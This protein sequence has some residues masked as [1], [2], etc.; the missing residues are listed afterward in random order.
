[1]EISLMNF[2]WRCRRRLEEWKVCSSS[3]EESV[4]SASVT[5]ILTSL[6]YGFWG[7][8]CESVS[9]LVWCVYLV[10]GVVMVGKW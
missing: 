1:M 3:L 9:S 10:G 5:V 4:A 8:W 6:G 2:L 7:G